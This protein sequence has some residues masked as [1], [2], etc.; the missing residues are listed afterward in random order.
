MATKLDDMKK[1]HEELTLQAG[2]AEARATIIEANV[3]RMK[4]HA[5][6]TVLRAKA[7]KPAK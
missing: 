1:Q 2:I 4:A 5:E 7:S 3:R 6:Y